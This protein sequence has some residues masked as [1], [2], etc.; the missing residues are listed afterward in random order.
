[1]RRLHFG[2]GPN[3]LPAPWENFD[4]DVNIAQP[5]PFEDSSAAF[6]FAEHVIEHVPFL[7]GM[8]FL[9]E[10]LRVLVPGGVL[11]F[12]FP[13]VTR[14]ESFQQT[15]EYLL[16]LKA[17]NRRAATIGDVFRFILLDNGHR[18]CW[19]KDSGCA[20]AF[21]IGFGRVRV[22]Q[23]GQSIN[24]ELSGIDGHHRTSPV[25]LLETTVLEATK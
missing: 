6:I 4:R 13:D 23:Y 15:D 11:R 21:A 16:F 8:G 24:P 7:E 10:C 5:L 3:R 19:T 22:E 18:A 17:R 20:A 9:R 1:M 25:A 2:C 14:F 12:A